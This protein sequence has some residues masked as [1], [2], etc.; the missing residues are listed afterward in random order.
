MKI[1]LVGS[2]GGHLIQLR[3]LKKWWEKHSRFWVT[4]SKQDAVNSL[5]GES[6][7]WAYF[8]TNRNA[9]NFVR[10]LF[11]AAKILWREK[12]DIL[13]STGAGVSVP[14]FYIGKL[15]GV[16]LVF[17]EVF[18]RINSSTLTGRL[19]YPV[20][21]LFILQWEEQKIFYPKGI[22]LGQLI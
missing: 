15:L 12:P 1:C 21:D 6:V 20:A 13:I 5:K 17:I 14:F 4:F 8:P 9:L 10:N 2:S 7:Y 19:I 16:K 22:Y 3:N 18:D 11:L